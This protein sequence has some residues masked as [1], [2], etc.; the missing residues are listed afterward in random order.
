MYT[1]ICGRP[2]SWGES[3]QIS[4]C[5]PPARPYRPYRPDRP[6][7]RPAG[8]PHIYIYIC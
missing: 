6:A 8:W 7:G 5:R 3:G 2:G 1:Y 4:P